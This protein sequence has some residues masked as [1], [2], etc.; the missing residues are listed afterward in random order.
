MRHTLVARHNRLTLVSTSDFHEL[1]L[2]LLPEQPDV[3]ECLGLGHVDHHLHSVSANGGM[4]ALIW[5]LARRVNGPTRV[6]AAIVHHCGEM[7]PCV[8]SAAL[9]HV[10]V[11]RN[12]QLGPPLS[13]RQ[14]RCALQ[15]VTSAFFP[16]F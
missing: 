11:D 1:H 15:D 10:A 12:R 16:E 9:D 2:R 7:V 6:G 14:Q 13:N 8:P 3:R 5:A 4:E